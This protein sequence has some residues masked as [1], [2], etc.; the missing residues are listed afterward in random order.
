MCYISIVTRTRSLCQCGPEVPKIFNLILDDDFAWFNDL[1]QRERCG[2]ELD[3]MFLGVL[4]FADNL[5][6]L[7]TS[8]HITS[9][10]A[11]ALYKRLE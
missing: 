4:Y 2:V 11:E 6:L 5:W 9:D 3:D 7:A 8:S 10:M 1:C